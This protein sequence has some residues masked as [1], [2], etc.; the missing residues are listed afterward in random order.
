VLVS[1]HDGGV[2][3]R[4]LVVRVLRQGIKHPLPNTAVAPS[5]VTGVY[6]TE[7]AKARR[8][9]PPRNACSVAVQNGIHEQ[10][11]VFCCGARLSCLTRQQVFDA[12]P[13]PITEGVSFARCLYLAL[14]PWLSTVGILIDDTF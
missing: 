11:V 14:A 6:D 1:A 13:L 9:I 7:I 4:V 5:R 2:D 3:H 8:Q 12:R 10:P